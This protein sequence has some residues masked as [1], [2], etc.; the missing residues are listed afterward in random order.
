MSDFNSSA[1]SRSLSFMPGD[2]TND[3]ACANISIIDDDAYEKT[4]LFSLH[5]ISTQRNVNVG[6]L[7][8]SVIVQDDDRK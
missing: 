7:Y 5:I 2:S 1:D 4:E 3:I 6:I 8:A